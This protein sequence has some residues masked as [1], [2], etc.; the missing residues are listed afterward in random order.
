M[1]ANSEANALGSF[2]ALGKQTA[3]GTAATTL[4]KALATVSG[5]AP[6]FKDRESPAEHPSPSG[7]SLNTRR[8]TPV[9]HINYLAG[10]KATFLLHP[11]FIVPALMGAG[12]TVSTVA[13][14]GYYTHTCTL[15]TAAAHRWMTAA[16]QVDESDGAFV[17]RGVDMR[18]TS[19]KLG[20]SPEQIQCNMALRGLKVE[21][22]SGSPTYVSEAIDEIVPWLGARTT[23]TLNG[24]SIVERIR[25]LE[26]SVDNTMREDDGAVWEPALTSLPQQNIDISLALSNVN[27]S[28]DIYKAV[29]FGSASG[30]AVDT[31]SVS[32]AID[33]KWTSEKNIATTAVPY[34]LQIAIPAVEWMAD[35][36]SFEANGDNFIAPSLTAYMDD[37]SGS[38]P[39]T[40][41]VVNDVTSY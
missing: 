5:L 40:V 3:K 41:T 17:M 31:K 16:W 28:D 15:A 10:A 18:A 30:T 26:F 21:P 25:N 19:L 39:I 24:Y 35:A 38:A 14:T 27:I 29:F 12:F 36:E 6:I 4:Y 34:S 7:S 2:F 22:M 23:L 8:K 9:K 1:S 37:T 13:A 33:V 20:I 32:G 11:K